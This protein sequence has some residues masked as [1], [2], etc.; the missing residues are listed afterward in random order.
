[1]I[2]FAEGH[3]KC[4]VDANHIINGHLAHMTIPDLMK[5]EIRRCCQTLKSKQKVI[6]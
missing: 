3:A 6:K 4:E 5:D 2:E 1:M